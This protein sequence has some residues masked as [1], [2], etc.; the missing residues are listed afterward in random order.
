VWNSSIFGNFGTGE[1]VT[2]ADLTPGTHTITASATDDNG[3]GSDSITVTITSDVDTVDVTRADYRV[4]QDRWNIQGTVFPTSSS[5]DVYLNSV[6]SE[7]LIGAASVDIA[8]GDWSFNGTGAVGASDGN[9]VI[10]VSSGGAVS[11]LFSVSVR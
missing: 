3:T 1:V 6:V 5:V 10:A 2:T 9:T 8:T 4:R 11:D 7:N